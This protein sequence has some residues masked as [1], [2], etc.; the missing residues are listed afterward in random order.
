MS[1][2]TGSHQVDAQ[3][4]EEG[5]P[6]DDELA[7][8]LD[9]TFDD[10]WGEDA[11]QPAETG[12]A[13]PRDDASNSGLDD[14]DDGHKD[15]DEDLELEGDI[16]GEAGP[17]QGDP[18]LA[19]ALDDAFEDDEAG[20]GQQGGADMDMDMHMEELPGRSRQVA[21]GPSAPRAPQPPDASTQDPTMQAEI[22]KRKKIMSAMTEQQLDRYESFRRSSLQRPRVKKLVQSLIGG[23]P[24]DRA[25][26]ALCGMAKVYVGEL[27]EAA[28]LLA[29]EE[30]YQ[31]PLLPRH[32]HRAYQNLNFR[33]KVP[34]RN[35][36]PKRLF[37]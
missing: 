22:E 8:A 17:G 26:I 4:S 28:R 35:P 2:D 30:G 34:H 6:E 24:P 15:H 32:I 14:D 31:G 3:D 16:E 36:P 7:N 11:S 13:Q 27:V 18:D 9:E 21:A 12:A 25:I 37:K 5:Q 10:V 1:Q 19:E 20:P 33:N 23:P 29:A